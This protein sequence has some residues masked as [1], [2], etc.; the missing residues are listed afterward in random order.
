MCIEV[1]ILK[2]RIPQTTYDPIAIYGVQRHAETAP[3]S[4]IVVHI[5]QE[6]LIS[7][8]MYALLYIACSFGDKELNPETNFAALSLN[9]ANN[10]PI[11][12][13]PGTNTIHIQN[14]IFTNTSP[15]QT[16]NYRA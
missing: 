2:K 10:K 15:L 11:I 5:K 1:Y 7:L 6:F 4:I 12:K 16:G 8:A 14:P 9:M 3:A 13:N